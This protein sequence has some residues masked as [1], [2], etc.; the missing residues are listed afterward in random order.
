MTRSSR[1]LLNLTSKL[2]PSSPSPL[3]MLEGL[4]K[5]RLLA[6]NLRMPMPDIFLCTLC[7]QRSQV[8]DKI[9]LSP[10]LSMY[11]IEYGSSCLHQVSFSA[12]SEGLMPSW[13]EAFTSGPVMLLNWKMLYTTSWNW[14]TDI[15]FWGHIIAI[16]HC[17]L[18][19]QSC[20]LLEC[21]FALTSIVL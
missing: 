14:D 15:S 10:F 12:I 4:R 3:N 17:F 11:F 16:V 8:I 2:A 5:P 21:W 6:S 20:V 19:H 7:T 18:W 1:V 9:Q 13:L